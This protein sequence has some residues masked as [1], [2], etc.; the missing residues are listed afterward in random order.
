MIV[1]DSIVRIGSSNLASRSMAFDSECD[2][3]I[4]ARGEARVAATI[5]DFRERLLAEHLDTQPARVREE[6]ER[7]GGLH[8]AIAAFSEQPRTLRQ[9]EELPQWSEAVL[10]MAAVADP[11]EPIALEM[12]LSERHAEEERAADPERPAW[13]KLAAVIATLAGLMALW[14][15][16]P[17]REVA[18]AEA[19]IRWAKAF[20]EQWW[21]PWLLMAAY[22]PACLVMFPRPLITLAAVIAF[23][24]W[25]GFCYSLTGICASSAVTWWMG[26]HMRRDTVRRLAG[27]KLDRMAEV[28]RKHGL[29]AMTLLRLV[30]LAPFAV[31]SIVA[32]AIRMKLW[33]V[34][35]GTAIGL[36]PGTLTTTVFGDAIE[37]AISGTGTV[38]WWLVGGALALLAG[39]AWAVKRWFTRMERRLSAHGGSPSPAHGEARQQPR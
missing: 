21:A 7:S 1:D 5:R 28:L 18:S 22:T 31:E 32:G 20:G 35:L 30:P 9:L 10:T 27:A 38:N 15:F 11:E 23:G 3:A 19:A 36:L 16:T 37:T 2:L 33:H 24:P 13:G 6:V 39:G 8:G 26:R 17:L 34:V 29:L 25:W 14:Q 4:E 12:L